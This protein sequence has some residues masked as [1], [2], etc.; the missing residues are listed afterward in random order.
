MR[1]FALAVVVVF[2]AVPAVAHQ[3]GLSRGA[4]VV[5]DAIDVELTFARPDVLTLFPS[6]DADHDAVI[7]DAELAAAS[8]E[9]AALWTKV[10]V[11][12]GDAACAVVAGKAG[13]VEGDGVVVAATVDC[14]Q[15]AGDV[16]VTLEF[17][18]QLGSSHRHLGH[19]S[20]AAGEHDVV[21]FAASPTFTLT[22]APAGLPVGDYLVLGVEHILLGYDHLCFLLGL[23]VVLVAVG[24]TR[25]LIAVITAFTLAHSITLGLA[26]TGTFTLP[27]SFVEPMIAVSIVW[28]GLESFRVGDPSKRWRITFP[29]GLIHGFGFAGALAEIGLP[30][31]AVVPALALFNVGVEAGQLAVFAVLA[32]L[33]ILGRKKLQEEQRRVVVKAV[34]AAVVVAGLYWLVERIVGLL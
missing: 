6:I 4:W 34:S 8:R 20:A 30:K 2:A 24:K 33:L 16:V 29:F 21:A 26:A 5:G 10:K 18:D 3:V 14:A 7:S 9:T 12:K 32:P 22:S 11:V 28:V 1:S 31:D 25:S 23:V 13:L 19:V 27:S 17:F 15:G